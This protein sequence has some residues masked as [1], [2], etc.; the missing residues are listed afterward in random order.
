M[1]VNYH[2]IGKRIRRFRLSRNISQEELALRI[3]TS[4][5]YISNIE[6]G[7]NRPTITTLKKIADALGK[8]LFVG[9][10]D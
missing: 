3:Q 2:F 7:S 6:N 8:R 5:S 1:D 4:A 10:N 9:F